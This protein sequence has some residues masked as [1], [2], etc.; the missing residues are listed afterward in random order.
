MASEDAT[1]ALR[2]DPHVGLDELSSGLILKH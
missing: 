1:G 2:F